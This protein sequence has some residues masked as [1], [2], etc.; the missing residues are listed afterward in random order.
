MSFNFSSL[1]KGPY[2]YACPR[3]ELLGDCV[4]GYLNQD[5]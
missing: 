1:V 2:I 5:L 3:L 4:A